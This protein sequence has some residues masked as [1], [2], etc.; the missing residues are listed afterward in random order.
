MAGTN[1]GTAAALPLQDATPEEKARIQI[2]LIGMGDMGRLYASRFAA[3]GWKHINVCDQ[4]QHF[5]GLK[6]EYER[7]ENINVFLN[8]HLVSR[9]SDFIIYSVEA[10]YLR[11]AV[12]AYG[13]STKPGAIVS[14]QTSVKAPEKK[15]FEAHLPQDVLIISC[16]SLHGPKVDTA[17]QPLVLIQHRAP[18]AS[19]RLVERIFACFKSRYV[20]LS[21]EE[22]DTV[23]ANTQAV[24]H[25]AFLSMG[26]AWRCANDYPWETTRYPGGIETVKINIMLRIYSA[27]W[28]VYAGLAILNP[29]ARIQVEQYATSTTQLF[30]LMI[31]ERE[32]D[33]MQRVFEGR[34]KVFGWKD[35]EEGAGGGDGAA[36]QAAGSNAGKVPRKPILL[37][38][39]LL[40]RFHLAARR[41]I[42][43][44]QQ[45]AAAPTAQSPLP[46]SHLALLAIVDCW[47]ALGIDPYAHLE[48][49]ATPVFRIWI[50]VCEYLF[51]S[52]HRLRTACK[53]AVQGRDYRTDDT[54][55]TIAARGWAEAVRF[56]NFDLYKYRFEETRAFFEPRFE[57]AAK[58]GAEMLKVVA[59]ERP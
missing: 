3:A 5:E 35:D 38:D 42:T 9:I 40:D 15:A 30:K 47:S 29:A 49:A 58:A 17:G 43:D 1:A 12:A 14:G 2:G 37:S 22:H 24:T 59:V 54:E 36:P 56:G 41:A 13:P 20:Y 28:H 6:K 16:H 21:Y 48:L 55:F 32:D 51:R 26:T 39:T 31:A 57:E 7:N 50:G 45:S 8:G 19:M 18:D 34:R 25:A 27:K 10:A 46:N 4:P 44:G 33:L 23:T 11:D 52:P 53:A